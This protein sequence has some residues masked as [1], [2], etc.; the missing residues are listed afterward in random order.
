MPLGGNGVQKKVLTAD[1]H[2][3]LGGSKTAGDHIHRGS[4]ARA[5]DAEEAVELARLDGAGQMI[6][7]GQISVSFRQIFQFD[8]SHFLSDLR[9]WV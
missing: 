5:V 6:H 4:L 3:S 2:A 1:R 9:F 8:H 7:R